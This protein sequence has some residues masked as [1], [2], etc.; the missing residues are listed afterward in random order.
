M[1]RFF[2]ILAFVPSFLAAFFPALVRSL[3]LHFLAGLE[4]GKRGE[5]FDRVQARAWAI[6]QEI[7]SAD[8]RKLEKLQEEGSLE[9]LL[10]WVRDNTGR[11]VFHTADG[12]LSLLTN[13]YGHETWSYSPR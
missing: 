2:M 13:E 9:L 7:R 6:C 10:G 3:W 5:K 4:Q 1:N 12:S 11:T 8:L